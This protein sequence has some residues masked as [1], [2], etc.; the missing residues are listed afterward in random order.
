MKNKIL[1]VA[2]W[3]YG[4]MNAPK[5]MTV[6]KNLTLKHLNPHADLP[7]KHGIPILRAQSALQVSENYRTQLFPEEILDQ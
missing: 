4:V 6:V 3:P 5:I 7:Y 1:R 2:E